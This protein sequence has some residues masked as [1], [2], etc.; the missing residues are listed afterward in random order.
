MWIPKETKMEITRHNFKESLGEIHESIESASFLAIDAE[1]TGLETEGNFIHAFDTPEDRYKKLYQ[2]VKSFMIIQ[3]GLCA[4]HYNKKTQSYTTKVFNFYVFPRPYNRSAPDAKFTCQTSSLEFLASKGMDFGKVFRDG[5]SYLHSDD[6]QKLFEAMEKRRAAHQAQ[7]SSPDSDAE[8]PTPI[9]NSPTVSPEERRVIEASLKRVDDYLNANPDSNNLEPLDLEPCDAFLRKCLFE[10]VR[11]RF[12]P[13]VH[14]ES[15][16]NDNK[17]RFIRVSFPQ[18]EEDLRHMEEERKQAEKQ[19]LE[20]AV[21]FSKVIEA[22]SH[23]KKLVIGHNM[24]LD[25]LHVINRFC[26]ELP[27]DYVNFKEA[28]QLVFPSIIDTKHMANSPPFNELVKNKD[29]ASLQKELEKLQCGQEVKA[30][31]AEGFPNYSSRE[32][33]HEAGYDAYLTGLCFLRMAN[34][35]GTKPNRKG[36]SRWCHPLHAGSPFLHPF[37][38]KLYLMKCRDVPYC[39]LKGNDIPPSRDH[40]F[41]VKVQE[42]KVATDIQKLFRPFGK[43]QI[44]WLSDTSALV[45]LYKWDQVQRARSLLTQTQNGWCVVQTY[46][47][48]VSTTKSTTPTSQRTSLKRKFP[49]S[50]HS[51][52][53]RKKP[54]L[55]APAGLT[56]GV[57]ANLEDELNERM[58][59]QPVR[60]KSPT[61][62]EII[63]KEEEEPDMGELVP[64]SPP[65]D[66]LKKECESDLEQQHSPPSFLKLFIPS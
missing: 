30:D 39:N 59:S 34:Y 22:I 56:A 14:L 63:G 45:G 28:A 29:L 5:I 6:K 3:F 57:S 54:A 38:N 18:T 26:F 7:G 37:M 43:I 31:P 64:R 55:A 25:L 60:P 36:H 19:E 48:Y 33:L 46:F 20:D 44:V 2:S 24:I 23:Y 50:D 27:E 62:L 16:L 13:K 21:G 47:E 11:Q 41:H 52:L 35:L 12:K 51:P 66:L 4:F 9:M 8:E 61:L 1:F 32:R 10:E 40:V 58:E 15:R 65:E 17:Q 49:S 53:P 42:G